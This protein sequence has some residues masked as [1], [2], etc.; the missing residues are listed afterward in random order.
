MGTMVAAEG[1]NFPRIGRV[2]AVSANPTLQS[3][4]EVEWYCQERAPHKPRWLRY[5]R[6]STDSGQLQI[7]EIILY[8]FELTKKGALKKKTRDYLK[9]ICG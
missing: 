7:D 2:A 6:P 3:S 8:D 1:A 9:E 5:F 4:V